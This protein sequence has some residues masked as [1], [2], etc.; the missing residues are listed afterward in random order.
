MSD[1]FRRS[2]TAPDFSG[3][4]CQGH[5]QEDRDKLWDAANRLVNAR[6]M[7]VRVTAW[8]STHIQG[9]A[10]GLDAI[11]HR[12]FGAAW[13][14]VQTKA[15]EAIEEV[16]GKIHDV[17]A[18]G[19]GAHGEK[20][21]WIWLNRLCASA[22]GA[23]T[24]FIGLPGLLFDIPV[25]TT[26]MLRSIAEI[27]REHGEDIHSEDGKRACLEVLAQGGPKTEIERA[28]LGYWSTRAGLTH[29]TI[30]ALT[31]TVAAR[32]GLRMSEK[33]L[34]QMVP[35][36]GAVAGGGLNWVFMGYYQEMARVHFTIREIERRTGDPAGVRACFDRLVAQAN[37]LKHGGAS[38][39]V[40]N[41]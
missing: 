10:G 8:L 31:R 21:S 35:V 9:A 18:I 5:S 37:A 34:A 33:I 26:L 39:P 17:A 7:A 6:S 12:V 36:A 11:G 32:L 38:G 27:A 40:V 4:A 19:L 41:A 2:R 3:N 13:D 22:S 23:V 15:Q 20:D 16:L 29:L 28:E 30:N 24:G 25:T 14:T 1:L